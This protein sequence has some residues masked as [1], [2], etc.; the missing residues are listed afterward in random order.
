MTIKK[1]TLFLLEKTIQKVIDRENK[2]WK[3]EK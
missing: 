2:N 3:Y 1:Q